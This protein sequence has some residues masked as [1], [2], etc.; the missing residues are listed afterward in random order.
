MIKDNLKIIS[1]GNHGDYCCF[2]GYRS[3]FYSSCRE[4]TSVG[5]L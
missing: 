4:K 5:I 1:K 3:V 2:P